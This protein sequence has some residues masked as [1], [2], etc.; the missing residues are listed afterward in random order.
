MN[1]FFTFQCIYY[2]WIVLQIVSKYFQVPKIWMHCNLQDLEKICYWKYSTKILCSE[3][4]SSLNQ[5]PKH[6][7]QTILDTFNGI[8]QSLQSFMCHLKLVIICAFI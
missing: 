3:G 7:L 1:I 6:T 8:L 4:S 2:S 5:K